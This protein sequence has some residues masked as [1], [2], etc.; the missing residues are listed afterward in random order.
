[1]ARAMSPTQTVS[2]ILSTIPTAGNDP[3]AVQFVSTS[4]LHQLRAASQN[5][6]VE[7]ELLHRILARCRVIVYQ[8]VIR[9]QV[10]ADA[11]ASL[12]ERPNP[13]SEQMLM[14]ARE[15]LASVDARLGVDN[16]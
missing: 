5:A 2:D 1:M 15:L 10:Q 14:D 9:C 13:R 16:D 3:K 4:T 11:D 7:E 12:G 8:H 6:V